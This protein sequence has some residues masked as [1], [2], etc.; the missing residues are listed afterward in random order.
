MAL[1]SQ[2][3][4]TQTRTTAQSN[5]AM[6]APW[7]KPA[8]IG[9][10]LVVALVAIWFLGKALPWG[11]SQEGTL[12]DA[13][14]PTTT[15]TAGLGTSPAPAISTATTSDSSPRPKPVD[16]TALGTPPAVNT[17][18]SD[19]TPSKP[20]T[21]IP[22]QPVVEP[23]P[24]APKSAEMSSPA[25]PPV[26]P[27]LMAVQTILEDAQRA[28]KSNSL[29]EA[30]RLFSK[31]LTMDKITA[32]EIDSTRASLATINDELVFSAKVYTGD[33]LVTTYTVE[34]GDALTKIARKTELATD[35]RLIARVNGVHPDRLRIGQKLKLVRGPFHAVVHKKAFR[36]DIY[37]GS[38]DEPDS[39][40]F[41]RSFKVGLGE[42]NG[43]PVGDFVIRRNSKLVN[44][45]W[46]N[47]RTGE[48]FDKND[49]KN[50]IGERWLGLEGQGSAATVAGMG[51]HG[52]IDPDSIG[53]SL[54]MGCVR[55]GDKDV[56]IVYELLVEQ[57][58][59]VR[60]VAE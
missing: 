36:M 30:R 5:R 28:M 18:V 54:S 37:A 22:T 43:T 17:S 46:T 41:I 19:T 50:P 15:S 31:A 14:K 32:S 49:P 47:P 25:L 40:L 51:I 13:T 48:Q 8:A 26:D 3:S 29:V 27:A 42:D 57:V 6:R 20:N 2:G 55:L 24:I 12:A 7:A 56:E 60:I 16:V 23:T 33:P 52:T 39:W 10:L 21:G 44:P 59:R 4:R 35:W 1:P 38:P 34:S 53:K 45:N 9:V 11:K 58:S